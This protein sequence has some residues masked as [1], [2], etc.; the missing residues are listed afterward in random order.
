MCVRAAGSRTAQALTR[1]LAVHAMNSVTV[2]P[3]G[4]VKPLPT[5]VRLPIAAVDGALTA[6][7]LGA[8]Y[9]GPRA[10]A[11]GAAALACAGGVVL[12]AVA[13]LGEKFFFKKKHAT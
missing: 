8:A 13:Y 1:R 3:G 12:F 10:V 2:S 5:A 6:L 11:G 7:C 9:C 4:V